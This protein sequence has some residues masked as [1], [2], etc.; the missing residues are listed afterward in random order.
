MASI[1]HTMGKHMSDAELDKLQAWKAQGLSLTDM[2]RRLMSMRAAARERGPSLMT[3]RRALRG[4]TFRRSKVETRGRKQIL[5]PANLRALDRARKRLIAKAD[6]EYEV[7]WDDIVR[8]ARVPNVDRT[9]AAKCLRAA[10]YDISW[11]SPRLK[12]ARGEVDEEQR[13]RICNKWRKLPETFW[14]DTIDAYIDCKMW[15]VP[16]SVKGRKFLNKLRV[17]GHLRTKKEGLDKGCTKPDKRKHHMNVGPNVKLFA[18]IVGNRVRV[19]H[20][21]DGK[22]SSKA[23]EAVYKNVLAT[24]L[25][26]HRGEKRCYDIVED[27]DPTGF[28]AAVAIRAKKEVKI[29]PIEFPTYSPDLNPCDYSLWEEIENRMAT[30]KTPRGED[31]AGFKERLRR[32]ALSIPAPVIRKMLADMKPRA[33]QVYERK[34]GH[35]PK[36]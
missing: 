30:Q 33:R 22:W 5:T 23:A 17:R 1:A 15:P 34:G 12:P 13:T 9:T 8:A 19:W 24:A 18:A 27:N 25:K 7:H 35:I 11:R 16:R 32:T 20:Y 6:G 26:R 21:L 29:K 28:K 2:R 36:D 14:T 4:S 10:G 3:I 31:V